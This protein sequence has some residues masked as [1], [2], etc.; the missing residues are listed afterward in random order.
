VKQRHIAEF[1][2]RRD[3]LLIRLRASVAG[4]EHAA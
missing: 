1:A 2:A 4:V 3:A